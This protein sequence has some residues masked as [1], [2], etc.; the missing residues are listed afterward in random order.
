MRDGKENA[1]RWFKE[2][3]GRWFKCNLSP[4]LI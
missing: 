3:A 1:G 2:N 4:S